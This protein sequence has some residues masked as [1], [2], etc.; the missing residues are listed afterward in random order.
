MLAAWIGTRIL[1][2]SGYGHFALLLAASLLL[3]VPMNWT[4]SSL[5]RYGVQELVETGRIAGTFWT[6]AAVLGTNLTLVIATS[7]LWIEPLTGLLRVPPD[8]APLLLAHVTAAVLWHHMQQSLLAAKLPKINAGLITFERVLIV[9]LLVSAWAAGLATLRMVV[10]IYIAAAATSTVIALIALRRMIFPVSPIR[11]E[12]LVKILRFS[13]PLIASGLVS[14]FAS[15]YLDSFF[16]ARFLSAAALGVYAIAF[17]FSGAV[18]QVNFLAGTLLQPF[19]ISVAPEMQDQRIRQFAT[20]VLPVISLGWS[21]LCVLAALAGGPLLR[22]MFGPQYALIES[23]VWPLMAAVALTGPVL[24]GY[25]PIAYARSRTR[26]IAINAIV[27]ATLNVVL[28]VILIPRYGLLGCAWATVL[29]YIGAITTTMLLSDRAMGTRT[30][31]VGAATL[32]ALAAAIVVASQGPLIAVTAAFAVAA[33][34]FVLQR[35]ELREGAAMLTRAI[36][37]RRLNPP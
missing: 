3:M 16:I 6:R 8:L 30:L 21:I 31:W 26:I 18:M 35:Q 32:P 24:A 9:L 23:L 33:I 37:W 36:R 27:S 10:A 25:F 12:R 1:G 13:A 4:L 17:Q 29:A 7:P 28:N 2:A 22:L 5:V 11:R 19:F 34:I 14:Y 15:S 20:R